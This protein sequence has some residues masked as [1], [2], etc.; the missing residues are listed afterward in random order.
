MSKRDKLLKLSEKAKAAG[1]PRDCDLDLIQVPL[2]FARAVRPNQHKAL[3]ALL[4]FLVDIQGL[5]I[6][7]QISDDIK[8]IISWHL[9]QI[10]K[11]MK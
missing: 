5:R 3:Q 10:E 9:H 2:H 4:Q 6:T 11:S 7:L 1:H 8:A